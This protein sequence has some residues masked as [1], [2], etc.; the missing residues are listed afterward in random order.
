MCFLCECINTE[1]E[2]EIEGKV[3]DEYTKAEIPLRNIFVQAL[4]QSEGKNSAIDAGQFST[5]SLGKFKYNLTKVKN[6]HYYIFNIAGDSNYA[7]KIHKL[8]LFEL[9]KNARSLS[10]P[11]SRLADL[12]II[13]Y[14][15][16]TKP[17]ADTLSLSWN[18]NGVYYWDLYPYRI[19]NYDMAKSLNP[20]NGGELRWAG[21]YVNS[22]VKTKVYADKKTK[23]RFDLDRYGKRNEFIDTIT[24]K[25]DR[26]NY[27]NFIY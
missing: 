12:S 3:I 19:Y 11:L 24:C 16:S 9:K 4:I 15:K 25:R 14:R 17:F 8:G 6:V 18:S 21:G 20:A 27:I 10:F 26:A 13:I 23:L 2:L 22:V 1:G 7:F 5:D